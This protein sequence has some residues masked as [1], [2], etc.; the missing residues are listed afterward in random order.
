MIALASRLRKMLLGGFFMRNF[1]SFDREFYHKLGRL[2]LPISLQTLL[3][4][5]VGASDAAMLGKVSQNAMAG[6]SLATQIAFVHSLFMETLVFG[7]TVLNAQY[8]GKGDRKTLEKV[9]SLILRYSVIISLLFT[10]AAFLVPETLMRIFTPEEALIAEGI[11]YLRIVSLSYL[12][13]G[14]SQC[15]LCSMKT[16]D[17]AATSAVISGISVFVNIGLNAIFIFGLLGAPAMGAAGA[18]LATTLTRALELI[19][20]LADSF[21]KDHIRPDL[22][23]LIHGDR[24]LEKDF[25]HYSFPIFINEMVWGGGTTIYSIIMGHLGGDATAANSIAS[26]VKNLT[27]CL[28]RGIGSGG[29]ILLGNIMGAG[30]LDLAKVYGRKLCILSI[31]CGFVTAAIIILCGPFLL[32]FMVLTETAQQYLIGMLYICALNMMG[33]SINVTVVVGIFNSGGDT[34]F[35]AISVFLSMWLFSI[36][37]ALA[38]AYWWD[39]PVLVTYFILS[40]DEVIRLPWVYR[41]YKKYKWIRNITR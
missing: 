25:W 5:T 27:V 2:M 18:A 39:L 11:S 34:R 41:H 22:R 4:A 14:I 9:F 10:L 17:R 36:P 6:V 21:F 38:S 1:V 40:M 8:W 28:C 37:L 16:S 31:F 13:T 3:L 33:A 26:V 15:Y 12:L 20:V 35:D 23:G 24:T 32:S 7:A 30:K 19:L 29:G